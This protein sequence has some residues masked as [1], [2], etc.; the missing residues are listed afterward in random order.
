MPKRLYRS[1]DNGIIAGVCAGLGDYFDIDPV[2][3]RIIAVILIFPGG[4][5]LIGYIVAWIAMPYPPEGEADVVVESGE[6]AERPDV[7]KYL[8][9]AILIA[10]GVIFLSNR[11][12]WWF[13]FGVI[14]PFGL[15]AI[16]VILIARTLSKQKKEGGHDDSVA[17]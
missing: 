11:L 14:W 4:V 3:I 7:V 2:L 8:P 12:F 15:I 13:D 9:G 17:T 10:L 16:G 1:R 6:P 5:G